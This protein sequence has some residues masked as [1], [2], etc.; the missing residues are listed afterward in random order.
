M[1]STIQDLRDT[2]ALLD[3]KAST[4]A[5]MPR[6]SHDVTAKLADPPIGRSS[7]GRPHRFRS[8]MAAAA[9]AA[10][11]AGTSAIVVWKDG[12]HAAPSSHRA[13]P[14]AAAVCKD[15]KCPPNTPAV[16]YT[17]SIN[18]API[19]YVHAGT[20]VR[21]NRK[22]FLSA[23]ITTPGR[24]DSIRNVVLYITTPQNSYLHKK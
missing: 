13:S 7:S 2:F 20:P 23:S 1:N 18:G 16:D 12:R 6:A 14:T 10:V 9:V 15:E 21:A 4:M 3:E 17:F 5:T 22:I 8:S 24:T 11:A 19:P